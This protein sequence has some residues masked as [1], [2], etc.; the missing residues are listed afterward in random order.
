MIVLNINPIIFRVGS[1]QLTYYSLVY[2]LALI[3]LFIIL[4]KSA[5]RKELELNE[6][7][8]YNFLISGILGTIIG[9][10]IFHILFWDFSYFSANPK[11]IIQIW[12]GGLSFH[13]GLFGAIVSS[14]I[15]TRRKNISFLKLA[16]LLIIPITFFLVL[17]RIANLIQGEIIGIPTNVS[18]CISFPNIEDCRHPI[19]LYA[20]S[21]RF[22]LFVLLYKIKQTNRK[23]GFLFWIFLFFISLGRFALDFLREDIRYAALTPGQWLSVPFII[24]AGYALHK[25]TRPYL[26]SSSV[27]SR[28]V[29]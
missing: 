23:D 20:A 18:R 8:I 5:R 24:V 16:D 13:G 28:A 22:L 1:F 10:R 2:I 14:L 27:S 11:E 25:V 17:G 26:S 15:Y 12:R 4:R 21:G 7:A 3:M 6:S 29:Q 19:Q 9:A